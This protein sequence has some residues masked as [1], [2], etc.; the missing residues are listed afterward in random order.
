MNTANQILVKVGTA[1][2]N[3][4]FDLLMEAR[5][6]LNDHYPHNIDDDEYGVLDDIIVD[7]A[8]R[9]QSLD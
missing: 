1:L 3:S 4:D 2:L 5:A 7:L 6:D 8:Q 9:L